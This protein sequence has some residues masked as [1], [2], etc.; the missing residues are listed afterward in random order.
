[1]L[2]QPIK[3]NPALLR[4][5]KSQKCN[6]LLPAAAKTREKRQNSALVT[7]IIFISLLHDFISS[8]FYVDS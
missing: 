3:Q 2:A 6:I 5:P 1:L 4:Q 8:N 7:R